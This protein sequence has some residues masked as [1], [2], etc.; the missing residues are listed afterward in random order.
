MLMEEK[1]T[2]AGRN[3]NKAVSGQRKPIVGIHDDRILRTAD[4]GYLSAY[5]Q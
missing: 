1:P 4:H 3:R 2:P 5:A